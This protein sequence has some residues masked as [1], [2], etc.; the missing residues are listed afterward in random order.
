[1]DPTTH[2]ITSFREKPASIDALD[3]PCFASVVFYCFRACTCARALR[4]A[5][6]RHAAVDELSFG[7][8]VKTLVDDPEYYLYGLKLSAGFEL[9][10]AN[11]SASEYLRC[12]ASYAW[13]APKG[14][15]GYIIGLF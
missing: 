13:R 1:M 7:S 2:R 4:Y 12:I 3:K 8:F 5:T 14:E 11:V 10:G 9:I 15:G 6:E